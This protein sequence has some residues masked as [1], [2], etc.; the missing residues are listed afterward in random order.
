M[1]ELL[2]ILLLT[3]ILVLELALVL[4]TYM[5]DQGQRRDTARTVQ[6]ADDVKTR[7]R[8]R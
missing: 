7:L 1:T 4:A 3:L 2:S 6:R 8:L 5:A